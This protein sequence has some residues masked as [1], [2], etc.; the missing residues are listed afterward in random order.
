MKKKFK[1]IA[2]VE[3][4]RG[5]GFKNRLP[6][7][8][9]ADMQW[10]KKTT[11]SSLSCRKNAVIMGRHTWE[12]IPVK[13]RPL[14]DRQNIIITSTLKNVP[15]AATAVDLDK[16]LKLAA[17]VN[18]DIFIIGGAMLYETALKHPDFSELIIT[19]INR[20]YNCDTFFPDYSFLHKETLLQEGSENGVTFKMFSRYR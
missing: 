2:A 16:G 3:Q 14:A 8:L 1:I 5:I 13:R 12:T 17:A 15:G 20:K 11:T 18:G 9:Q 7:R 10:F 19:E 6:W 4:Q